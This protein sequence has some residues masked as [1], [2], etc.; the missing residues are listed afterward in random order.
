MIGLAPMDGITDAAFRQ[1]T[2]HYG[3]PDLLFTEFVNVDGL[4]VGK[5]GIYSHLIYHRTSTPIYAQ[6]FGVNPLYFYNAALIICALGFSGVDINMGCPDK[7]VVKKGG[8]AGLINNPVLAKK[9]IQSIK[10]AVQDWSNGKELASLDLRKDI[11]NWINDYRKR[12]NISD[13][14]K[15]LPV[16]V[17]TRI[18][19]EKVTTNEWIGNLL[20]ADLAMIIIHGRTLKQMYKGKADWEEIAK[21]VA[22]AKKTKTKI[23]GNGDI[24]SKKEALEKINQYGVA[25]VLI[26]RAALGNPWVFQDY[27]PTVKEKYQLMLDHCQAFMDLTPNLNFLSLRKHL[28]WYLKGV[29]DSHKIKNQ[30]AKVKNIEEVR[31][32]VVCNL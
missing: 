5:I 18:G 3:H 9:I 31:R 21:A 20:E 24:K 28:L 13:E 19:Y 6:L 25:G 17:K 8:G 16:S 23:F 2:D 30:L 10:Q 4:N 29:N 32:L 12:K 26:G 1:I 15:L 22:M 27:Q 14:R 11:F 7:S